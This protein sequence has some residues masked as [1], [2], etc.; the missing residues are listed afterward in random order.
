[1]GGGRLLA[2]LNSPVP[3]RW[4]KCGMSA[5]RTCVS[6]LFRGTIY[7]ACAYERQTTRCQLRKTHCGFRS[8]G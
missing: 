4:N 2:G 6:E 8:H 7:H 3:F 1:D 5:Y